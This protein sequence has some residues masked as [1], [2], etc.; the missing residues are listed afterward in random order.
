[1]LEGVA[2]SFHM[3]RHCDLSFPLKMNS[4][5]GGLILV[6]NDLGTS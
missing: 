3:A 4:L 6:G 1:M 5:R 2:M